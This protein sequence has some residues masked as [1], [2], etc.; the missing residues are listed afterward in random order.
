HQDV[1]GTFKSDGSFTPKVNE[2][3]DG[4]DTIAWIIEQPWSDG[5]IGTYGPSY[6]GMTQ[7]AVATADTPG[8]KAIAPT[9]AAANWYSGLWYSQGGALSLSLVTQWNAMMYAA[10]EQRSIQRGEKSDAT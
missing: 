10:D 8:L 5:D 6:L 4:Q 3:T 9:A 1:R 7:W 2:V